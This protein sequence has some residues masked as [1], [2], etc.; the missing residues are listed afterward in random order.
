MWLTDDKKAHPKNIF[1]TLLTCFFFLLQGTFSLIVE[2]WHEP[3]SAR[4][5]GKDNINLYFVVVYCNNIDLNID[6][7]FE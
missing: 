5:L 2:A 3:L 6:V 1:E 7:V 4:N